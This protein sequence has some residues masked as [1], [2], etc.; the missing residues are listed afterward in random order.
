MHNGIIACAPTPQVDWR[1]SPKA[2][3]GEHVRLD[4][5]RRTIQVDSEGQIVSV[6][7]LAHE[8]FA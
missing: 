5:C 4:G 1:A 2:K 7:S 3:D 8:S 6:E